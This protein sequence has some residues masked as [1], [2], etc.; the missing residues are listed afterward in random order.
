MSE[1]EKIAHDLMPA[2]TSSRTLTAPEFHQLT[3]VPP[4]MDSSSSVIA[5]YYQ[6][7]FNMGCAGKRCAR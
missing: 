1:P 6:C 5:R 3:Q 2:P 4:A 7:C